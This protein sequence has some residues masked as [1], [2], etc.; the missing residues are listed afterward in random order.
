M[1]GHPG[2]PGTWTARNRIIAERSG[3]PVQVSTL[4]AKQ[5]LMCA[6]EAGAHVGVMYANTWTPGHLLLT[7]LLNLLKRKKKRDP[8]FCPGRCPPRVDRVDRAVG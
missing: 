7:Y 1:P 6:H 4:L 5:E 3:E 2:W 8:I